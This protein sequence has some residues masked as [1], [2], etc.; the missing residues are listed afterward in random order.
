M[1]QGTR[2][3]C[4]S[5]ICG[6]R[7]AISWGHRRAPSPDRIIKRSSFAAACSHFFNMRFLF[8]AQNTSVFVC[9][10]TRFGLVPGG[11]WAWA[12]DRAAGSNRFGKPGCKSVC[13]EIGFGPGRK[14][15]SVFPQN[16]FPLTNPRG[17][18]KL[19][20]SAQFAVFALQFPLRDGW[21]SR[22]RGRPFVESM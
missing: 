18:S 4:N 12:L 21:R 2:N 6:K 3:S 16:G 20:S 15:D 11:H 1:L 17:R 5:M 13:L 8:G 7:F 19:M 22:L 10:T 14:Q 9:K